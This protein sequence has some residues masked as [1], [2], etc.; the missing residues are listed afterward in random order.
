MSRSFSQTGVD[1]NVVTAIVVSSGN[2]IVALRALDTVLDGVTTTA[3][4]KAFGDATGVFDFGL[5]GDF[6][7]AFGNAFGEAEVFDFGFEAV[8]DGVRI[9][10][11]EGV[12]V[13]ADNL[14]V[15]FF[16]L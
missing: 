7:P 8:A 2:A 16:G 5:E 13:L 9:R 3:F 15:D 14:I 10:G 1:I 12:F 11:L 4:G 6:T